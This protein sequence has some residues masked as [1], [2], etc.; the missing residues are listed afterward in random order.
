MNKIL[1]LITAS[2]FLYSCQKEINFPSSPGGTIGVSGSLLIKA[3][4]KTGSDSAVATFTY[5]ANNRLIKES[6]SGMLSGVDLTSD[7]IIIRN[8]SGVITQIILK[9][10]ILSQSGL[11]SL[12]RTVY[13]DVANKRYSGT[14]IPLDLGPGYQAVDSTAFV[15]SGNKI[16]EQDE[17]GVLEFPQHF[18]LPAAK[19]T[20]EYNA[21]SNNI[22]TAHQFYT[23]SALN[24]I[25]SADFNYTYDNKTNALRLAGEAYV[26][27]QTLFFNANN[28]L[29]ILEKDLTGVSPA[30]TTNITYQY[31]SANLPVSSV[32]VATPGNDT[33]TT[34]YYYK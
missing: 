6:A 23:D 17:Y 25:A 33:Q 30:I 11:D 19:I 14:T 28:Q 4:T 9:S 26:L 20:Y 22:T 29:S 7:I 34:T 5:D 16:T 1:I 31:N 3:V 32:S 13:Y 15:Y 8:S 27:G 2:V 10:P 18:E 12:V 21:Q 24:Y